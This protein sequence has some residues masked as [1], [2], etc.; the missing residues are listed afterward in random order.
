MRCAILETRTLALL[1]HR[2]GKWQVQTPARLFVPGVQVKLC[3]RCGAVLQSRSYSVRKSRYAV[4]FYSLGLPL[5]ELVP[6]STQK[7][8]LL[9]PL[10]LTVDGKSV[11][12]LIADGAHVVGEV[13]VD[14]KGDQLLVSYRLFDA[15]SE[16]LKPSIRFFRNLDQIT[17]KAVETRSRTYAFDKPVSISRSLKGSALVW[18]SIRCQGI[19]DINSL[20]NIKYCAE[21][22]DQ[23]PENAY[24]LEKMRQLAHRNTLIT[25]PVSLP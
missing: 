6:G 15:R 8:Y 11:Y 14:V 19:Y 20:L 25:D 12:P 24:L 21:P 2:A 9:T 1:K 7:G 22:S 17:E 13:I 4:D 16:V 3:K 10:D 23:S 5:R 18:M